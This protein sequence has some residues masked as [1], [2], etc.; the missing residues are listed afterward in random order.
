[1]S[2]GIQRVHYI[3]PVDRYGVDPIIA[4]DNYVLL[5]HSNKLNL[6]L[7]GLQYWLFQPPRL[8]SVQGGIVN[9]SVRHPNSLLGSI[10]PLT[11]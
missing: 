4:F 7:L 1:M 8:A 3:G 2:D 6:Q 11:M 10:L 5:F 9:L